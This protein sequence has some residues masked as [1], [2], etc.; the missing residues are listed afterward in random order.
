MTILGLDH[1]QVTAPAGCEAAARHF[2]GTLLGL[3][4]TPKPE[5]VRATGGVWFRCGAQGI[6]VGIEEGFRPARKAHPGL[7][8]DGDAALDALAGRLVG[9]GVELAWDTR[10]AGVRRCYVRDPWGNRVELVAR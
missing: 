3:P 9:E 2:Y 10:I 4:E 5:G 6:H 7:A 1:V 8:V